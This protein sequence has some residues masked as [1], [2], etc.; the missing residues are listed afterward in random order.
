MKKSPVYRQIP[1]LTVSPDS[2]K[3]EPYRV[4][5]EERLRVFLNRR[6]LVEIQYLPGKE[7]ELGAGFLRS[8]GLI[9]HKDRIDSIDWDR[10]N[11]NLQI[12]AQVKLERS[13]DFLKHLALGSGCGMSLADTDTSSEEPLQ[14]DTCLDR[15]S[16]LKN[17]AG[18]LE[19]S[20]SE[21]V[22]RGVH[23][24]AVYLGEKTL[25]RADDI[26][27]HNAMDKVLGECFLK[28]TDLSKAMLLTTGR[29]T[30]EMAV[31]ALRHRVPL[32]A[33][34]S[35]ASTMAVDLA[36]KYR[37][38]LVGGLR[39]KTFTVFTASYRISPG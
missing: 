24:A 32:A 13:E 12:E 19:K 18:F 34:R 2:A 5:A 8:A 21:K 31:K 11:H 27:R 7:K 10:Q 9:N 29:L 37:L 22:T 23:S 25:C 6:P 28:G 38:C 3:H 16:V 30:F 35:V 14:A 15:A 20:R 1:L 4:V 36:E 39:G 33:S 26:G 17:L